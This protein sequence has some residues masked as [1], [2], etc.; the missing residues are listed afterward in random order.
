LPCLPPIQAHT[1]VGNR[2]ICDATRRGIYDIYSGE[3]EASC[4]SESPS[5]ATAWPSDLPKAITEDLGLTE[6]QPID[7]AIERGAVR[8]KPSLAQVRLSDLVAEA[9]RLGPVAHPK[10]V[11]W[12]AD[13]GAEAIEDPHS[14]PRKRSRRGKP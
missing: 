7:M 1:R 14:K 13:V 9:E 8:L 2:S 11:T 5:G 4:R 6:G 10:V 3:A 12:G